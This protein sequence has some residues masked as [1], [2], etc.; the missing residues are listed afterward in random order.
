MPIVVLVN[1]ESAS[2]SEITC[3]SLQDLDR[4]VVM[5]T[6]TYGKGLVQMTM[7]LPYN[8]NMKLTTA[9]YYIPSGRCIQAINYKHANGGYTEH[10]ADSL[11]KVFRTLHGREVRD[12]GGI[13]PDVEV[14]P[15][16]MSNIA[17]YLQ[18]A[19]ST[20]SM[21]NYAVEY[22]AQHPTIARPAEFELSDADYEA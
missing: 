14:K 16:T 21:R 10:V 13:R 17:M 8:G 2:S 12:G 4:A 15:D 1:G 5:G 11:T 3:G 20:S 9:K 6:R 19:D 7:D 22:I 18:G